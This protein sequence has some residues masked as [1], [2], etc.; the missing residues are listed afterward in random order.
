M[1]S[2][3]DDELLDE[4]AGTSGLDFSDGR[5][6]NTGSRDD[7]VGDT[8]AVTTREQEPTQGVELVKKSKSKSVVWTLFGFKADANSQPIDEN[9]PIC[10]LCQ[11]TIAVK[12]GNTSNLFSHLKNHHPKKYSELKAGNT[13]LSIRGKGKQ[14]DQPKI[15]SVQKY[16][17]N[18]KRWKQLTDA[19]TRG[20]AKDM[21]PV[22]SVEKPQ[23]DSR[24]ELPSRNI[25]P[26]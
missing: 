2:Y 17:R 25:F 16:T 11:H 21:M 7:Q 20:M 3:E 14:V 24:Y 19:V 8:S 12:G 18:S 26:K 6:D 1:E 9:K 13:E 5:G 4:G 23:F 22:Y 15:T 10:Q